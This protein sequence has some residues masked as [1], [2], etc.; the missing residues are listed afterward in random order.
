M[1][2]HGCAPVLARACV[3]ACVHACGALTLTASTALRLAPF[4]VLGGSA[5]PT[6]DQLKQLN[7]L[8]CVIKEVGAAIRCHMTR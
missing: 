2:A 4:R 8:A 7:Y 5:F 1:H 3:R 6:T